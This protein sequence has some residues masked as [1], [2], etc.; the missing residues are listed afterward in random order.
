MSL[1]SSDCQVVVFAERDEPNLA[2][3]SALIRGS[4]SVNLGEA[5]YGLASRFLVFVQDLPWFAQGMLSGVWIDFEATSSDRQRTVLEA[6]EART[7]ADRA[8]H[9]S[10]GRNH[11]QSID[12]MMALGP[13]LDAYDRA[14]SVFPRELITEQRSAFAEVLEW[15][16]TSM[17]I[18]NIGDSRPSRI[19]YQPATRSVQAM[20]WERISKWQHDAVEEGAG[21]REA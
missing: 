15:P 14:N 17:P 16:G 18:H 4:P 3:L 1:V 20:V 8:K 5:D 7:P 13:C 12:N 2:W 9:Y 19:E 21:H 10:F 11:W 6:L